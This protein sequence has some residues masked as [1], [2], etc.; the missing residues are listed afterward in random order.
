MNK[1]ERDT[2]KRQWLIGGACEGDPGE[3]AVYEGR[4]ARGWDAS[5]LRAC[6]Q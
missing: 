6:R 2:R 5:L 1:E 3:G 4:E